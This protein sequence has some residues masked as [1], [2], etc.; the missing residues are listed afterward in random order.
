[1]SFIERMEWFYTAETFPLLIFIQ[2]K[3]TMFYN[4]IKVLLVFQSFIFNALFSQNREKITL[5]MTAE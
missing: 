4:E 5:L 1:M 3:L 2:M